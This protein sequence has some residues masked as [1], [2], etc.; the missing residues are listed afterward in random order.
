MLC[1]RKWEGKVEDEREEENVN[2]DKNNAHF[3]ETNDIYSNF[4]THTY[5]ILFWM[6]AH[7]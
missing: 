2:N 4:N 3:K 6:K 5:F 1:V 7:S